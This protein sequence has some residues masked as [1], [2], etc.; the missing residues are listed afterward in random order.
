MTQFTP[1]SFLLKKE[2][3]GFYMRLTFQLATPPRFYVTHIPKGN[4]AKVTE[5]ALAGL[6]DGKCCAQTIICGKVRD[7]D[8]IAQL[9]LLRA[10]NICRRMK[11][12]S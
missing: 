11:G 1:R 10:H 12:N 4:L 7:G 5:S 6:E 2:V 8:T 3:Q 9:A